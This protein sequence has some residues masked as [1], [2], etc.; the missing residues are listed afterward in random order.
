MIESAAVISDCGTYRY[1]LE[2]RWA[3]GPSVTWIMLNPST[4][5]ASIDDPTIRRVRSFSERDGFGAC[6]VLN[7]FALRSPDPKLLKTHSE[8]VG[9]DNGEYLVRAMERT[10]GMVIA[11]WGAHPFAAE[12][13]RLLLSSAKAVGRTLYCLGTTKAG[14]PRHPLYVRGDQPWIEYKGVR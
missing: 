11:A 10:G 13:A 12:R 3:D 5:D 8:P 14:A 9:T 2:R 1:Q 6:E 7:L 4:A